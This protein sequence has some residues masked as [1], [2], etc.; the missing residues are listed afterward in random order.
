VIHNYSCSP[1]LHVASLCLQYG[2]QESLGAGGT[3]LDWFLHGGTLVAT[4]CQ[5]QVRD[6]P[7]YCYVRP[8]P[9]C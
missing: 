9:G 6:Y 5:N 7:T 2:K 3:S 1:I 8:Y 4:L